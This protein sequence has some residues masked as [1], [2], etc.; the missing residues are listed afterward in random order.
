MLTRS[1]KGEHG[2]AV[3][4]DAGGQAA[5]ATGSVRAFCSINLNAL[6]DF[7]NVRFRLGQTA[8]DR[9]ERANRGFEKAMQDRGA[10]VQCL[11]ETVAKSAAR[12]RSVNPARLVR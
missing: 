5:A 1:V 4:W 2:L 6:V 10:G 9:I 8:L 7:A 11:F 3:D 12:R